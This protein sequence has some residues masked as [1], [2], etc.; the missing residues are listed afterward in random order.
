MARIFAGCRRTVMAGGTTCGDTRMI[1]LR[2][3]ETHRA[4]MAGLARCW[5][6][7]VARIFP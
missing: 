1:E 2:S 6:R 4:G 7:Y 3:R 5:R